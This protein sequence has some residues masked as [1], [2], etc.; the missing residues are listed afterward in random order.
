M[1]RLNDTL[2]LLRSEWWW[3]LEPE[4]S[5]G[6]RE[7]LGSE[8][9]GRNESWADCPDC[10]LG[11]VRIRGIKQPCR[12]CG[13][14]GCRLVD[15]YTRRPIGSEATGVV[16]GALRRV[17]CDGCIGLDSKKERG[18]GVIPGTTERCP[19][20]GGSGWAPAF[21]Q[22]IRPFR[23]GYELYEVLLSGEEI[24]GD[25]VID[26]AAKR[27]K[28]GS[29]DELLLALAEL[30]TREL[31]FYRAT[32]ALEQ[33]TT[34]LPAIRYDLRA[35]AGL[36]FLEPRMPA[37]IRVP[38]AVVAWERRGAFDERKRRQREERDAA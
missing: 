32:V 4:T 8:P 29:Y 3:R 16:K 9:G 12:T 5:C 35:W 10:E 2:L 18:E 14:R 20:C 13:G 21:Q 22:R 28:A 36:C 24:S 34:P 7:R 27:R 1:S 26:S 23:S 25:P 11:V 30:R 37:L 6:H 31:R 38:A 33:T 15:A 17:P 19:Y